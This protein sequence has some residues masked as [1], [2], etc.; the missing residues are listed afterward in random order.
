VKTTLFGVLVASAL[1]S[2]CVTS[3]TD[4]DPVKAALAD[5]ETA[6]VRLLKAIG[7]YCSARHDLVE[8]RHRCVVEKNAEALGGDIAAFPSGFTPGAGAWDLYGT[9]RSTSLGAWSPSGIR[10]LPTW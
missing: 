1:L 10:R 8:A 7:S 6:Q 4:D 9:Q 2:A 5:R 3:R